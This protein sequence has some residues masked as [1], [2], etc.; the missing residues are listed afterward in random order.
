MYSSAE[1]AYAALDFTGL[2][3]VNQE[4]MLASRVVKDR[5]MKSFTLQEVLD[6]FVD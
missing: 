1:N 6:F 3:T 2:G 4:T 5:I